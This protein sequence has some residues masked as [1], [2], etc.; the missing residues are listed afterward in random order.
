MKRAGLP[1]TRLHDLR[2]TFASLMLTARQT[3]YWISEQMGHSS[4]VVT[5][6]VYAREIWKH[7]RGRRASAEDALPRPAKRTDATVHQLRA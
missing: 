1:P 5:L 3:P 4:P 2:H 7:T 6:T